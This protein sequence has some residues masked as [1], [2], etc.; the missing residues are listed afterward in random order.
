MVAGRGGGGGFVWCQVV[1][2]LPPW[3]GSEIPPLFGLMG[4]NAGPPQLLS[5]VPGGSSFAAAR[6]AVE[7]RE[8]LSDFVRPAKAGAFSGSKTRGDKSQ[9]PRSLGG[10]EERDR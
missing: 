10:R 2:K 5:E 4:E 8:S 1:P 3:F 7:M 9:K 6:W